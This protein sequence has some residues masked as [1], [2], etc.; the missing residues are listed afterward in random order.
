VRPHKPRTISHRDK[1]VGCVQLW[2]EIEGAIAIYL[3]VMAANSTLLCVHRDPVQLSHLREHGY[4]LVTTTSKHEGLRLFNSRPVDAIVLEHYEGI[5]DTTAIA[6]EIKQSRPDVPIVMLTDHLELA[7]SDLKSVDA[8]VLKADGPHFL[9]ATVHFVLNVK[10][11]AKG[12]QGSGP[13]RRARASAPDSFPP[14][15]RTS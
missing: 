9:L 4:E 3:N 5:A 10:A 12:R 8:L 11:R 2:A 6:D 14:K 13:E 7:D 1:T 15:S